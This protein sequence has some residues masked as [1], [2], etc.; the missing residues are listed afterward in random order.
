MRTMPRTEKARFEQAAEDGDFGEALAIYVETYRHVSFVELQQRLAPYMETSGDVELVMGGA[1]LVMWAGMSQG[2][3]DAVL[4]AE[5]NGRIQWEPASVLVYLI[6]GAV[7]SM[8]V[9]K[10]VPKGGYKAPRWLPVVWNPGPG[11]RGS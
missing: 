10:R 7:P 8:P 3:V 11:T 4:Q 5:R 1:N 9:A 6:D 2:F